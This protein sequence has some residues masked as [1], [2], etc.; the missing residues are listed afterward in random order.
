MYILQ[1]L[2]Y[3]HD[4]AGRLVVA[5]DYAPSWNGSATEVGKLPRAA[6]V[7]KTRLVV[8]DVGDPGTTS[9][10]LCSPWAGGVVGLVDGA[11]NRTCLLASF[12]GLSTNPHAHQ[13]MVVQR[14]CPKLWHGCLLGDGPQRLGRGPA[15]TCGHVP[16]SPPT[17]RRTIRKGT[18][19][20]NCF[21][22]G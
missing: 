17:N 14:L 4:V 10:R 7:S 6:S 19:G 12:W 1:V 21:N 15:R 3:R 8:D 18:G 22:L 20:S 13:S 16:L 11:P 5:A 2:S 9:C